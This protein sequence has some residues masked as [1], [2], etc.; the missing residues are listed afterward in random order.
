MHEPED[1]SHLLFQCDMTRQIW[2]SLGIIN[3]IDEALLTDRAGSAVLEHILWSAD[4]TMPGFKDLGLKETMGGMLV[5][6]VDSE[7]AHSW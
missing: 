3:F 1:V 5:Y 6:L 2:S 4:A 7:K